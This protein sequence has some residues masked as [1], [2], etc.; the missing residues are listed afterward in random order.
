MRAVLPTGRLGMQLTLVIL[1]LDSFRVA[2]NF[3]LL[4]RRLRGCERLGVG[5]ERSENTPSTL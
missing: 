2:G 5:R 1:V 3:L 4:G